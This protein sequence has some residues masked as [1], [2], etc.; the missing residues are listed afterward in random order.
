[1]NLYEGVNNI[2]GVVEVEVQGFFVER[3]I[4]L[5]KIENINIR[6]IVNITSG[7]IRFKIAIRDFKKLKK[8]AKK[9]KCRCK[10]ISKKGLYF[11]AFRY[12]KRKFVILLL[13]LFMFISV[14]STSFIWK[15]NITGNNSISDDE[16]I[17]AL[18]DSGIYIGKSKL[19]IDIREAIKNMRVKLNDAAWIGLNIKGK[20]LNVEIVEKTKANMVVNYQYGDIVSQKEGIIQKVVVENGTAITNAGDYIEKDRIVIEGKI[21]TRTNEI[22]DVEAKGK[23]YILSKYYYNSDYYFTTYYK[24]YNSKPKYSIG[25]DLNNSENYINYLDKSVKYDIIKNAKSFKLFNNNI[26][27]CLYKFLPYE[28]KENIQSK[29]EIIS[30]AKNE[31]MEYMENEVLPYCKES[32]IVDIVVNEILEDE[33]KISLQ[34]EYD[35]IEEVGAFKGRE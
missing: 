2:Y 34:I 4:N 14:F 24:E 17:E 19:K 25:V 18:R 29:E 15:I 35:V 13:L 30:K 1:M 33:E 11:N 16:V 32:Q 3:F 28:L 27:F 6:D 10:I 12:R 21:Y 26:S 20:T 7:I 9:T 8:I 31:A 22:M 5:C 23:I